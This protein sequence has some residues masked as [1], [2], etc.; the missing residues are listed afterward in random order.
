MSLSPAE[1]NAHIAHFATVFADAAR[2]N[3]DGRVEHCPDWNVAD[4][5][6]H[7]TEVHWF[8]RTIASERLPEPV[9]E[10]RRPVRP[11]DDELLLG[12]DSMMPAPTPQAPAGDAARRRFLAPGGE[13]EE[14]PPQPRVKLG[15]TLFERM[16]NATRNAGGR[17]DEGEGGE[18]KRGKEGEPVQA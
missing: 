10:S 3:L 18:S 14:A 13:G 8:W 5:V 6:W 7:V 2:D 1:C 11:A 4:L 16:Q 12:A 15:G 9:D 17:S